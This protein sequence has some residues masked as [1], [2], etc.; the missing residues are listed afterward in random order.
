MNYWDVEHASCSV[1][2]DNYDP[3]RENTVT[4]AAGKQQDQTFE[5]GQWK[6]VYCTRNLVY[7]EAKIVDV[8]CDAEGKPITG[9]FH[10]NGWNASHDEWIEFAS[11]RIVPH[12]FYTKMN[13]KNARDQEKYQGVKI[14][15]TI[16]GKDRGKKRPTG[17]GNGTKK[18]AKK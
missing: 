7:Y 9:K 14:P 4:V 16:L 6:D 5:V 3:E 1:E 17:K 18:K 2:N 10:F 11:S 8:K 13:T 15:T 12:H